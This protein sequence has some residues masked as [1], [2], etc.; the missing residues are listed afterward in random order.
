M[1]M[2]EI[3]K[4]NK[5]LNN[6]ELTDDDDAFYRHIGS[7]P[8][9]IADLYC[10][11]LVAQVFVQSGSRNLDNEVLK[12]MR[13]AI[14]ELA[15]IIASMPSRDIDDLRVKAQIFE[16]FK[17]EAVHGVLPVIAAASIKSDFHRLRLRPVPCWL[18]RWITH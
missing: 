11:F 1:V 17:P 18:R 16:S 9:T 15:M 13:Y 3:M 10:E 12:G 2:S 8:R 5:V 6:L 4:I 7:R 14:D